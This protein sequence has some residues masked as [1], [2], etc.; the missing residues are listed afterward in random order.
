MISGEVL[1]Q[2]PMSQTK[3]AL[4]AVGKIS[5]HADLIV[6][7]LSQKLIQDT[8]PIR[9]NWINKEDLLDIQGRTR[10][11][12]IQLAQELGI[13]EYPNSGGGCLLTDKGYTKRLKDLMDYD[14]VNKEYLQFLPYGRHFRINDDTKLIITRVKQESDI[15]TPLL[16]EEL[17]L[18]CKNIPGPLGIIQSNKE[19]SQDVINLCASILLRYNAKSADQEVVSFGKVFVL[20]NEITID[21]I[22]EIELNKFKIN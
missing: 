12:Q 20:E 2:R 6:R 15:I 22:S 21:R 9:E 7:P 5:R 13:K 10:A 3:N 1:K 16:K 19:N 17:V 4:I 14:S 11:R 18:K 8:L